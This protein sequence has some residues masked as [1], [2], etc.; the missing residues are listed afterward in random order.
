LIRGAV[1][2]M[3]WGSLEIILMCAS[4]AAQGTIVVGM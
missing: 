4:K 2:I 3:L 1:R